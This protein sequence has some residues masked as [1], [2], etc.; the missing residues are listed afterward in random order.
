MLESAR[1]VSRQAH[2]QSLNH[3]SFALC[4]LSLHTDADSL[5]LLLIL[6]SVQYT[7]F[8]SPAALLCTAACGC[9]KEYNPQCGKDGKTYGNP[10]MLKCAKVGLDYAGE[11]KKR[12]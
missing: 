7:E 9:S 8:T 11:C 2:G 6:S 10:C 3:H 12:K 1:N 4:I 5:L